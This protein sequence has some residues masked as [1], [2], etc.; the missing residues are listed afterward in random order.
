MII[1]IEFVDGTK[2]KAIALKKQMLHFSWFVFVWIF[3]FSLA[4]HSRFMIYSMFY[5]F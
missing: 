5:A 4:S 2:P 1:Y 3:F